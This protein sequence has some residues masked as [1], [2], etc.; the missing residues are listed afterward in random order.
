[1]LL[2]QT[3]NPN[4]LD[5]TDSHFCSLVFLQINTMTSTTMVYPWKDARNDGKKYASLTEAGRV[6]LKKYQAR[7]VTNDDGNGVRWK[8]DRIFCRPCFLKH[9]NK[10]TSQPQSEDMRCGCFLMCYR[11]TEKRGFVRCQ[12]FEP[13]PRRTQPFMIKPRRVIS[14]MDVVESKPAELEEERETETESLIASE[15]NVASCEGADESVEAPA[16]PKGHGFL[17]RMMVIGV[18]CVIGVLSCF[19]AGSGS[20]GAVASSTSQ[21]RVIVGSKALITLG[22]NSY[23]PVSSDACSLTLSNTFAVV[24]VETKVD[25]G[26]PENFAVL[27]ELLRVLLSGS[28]SSKSKAVALSGSR[29]L[30]PVSTLTCF[31][32]QCPSL[33]ETHAR[34]KALVA[35]DDGDANTMIPVLALLDSTPDYFSLE[36]LT[37]GGRASVS[38]RLG[39][40]ALFH[41]EFVDRSWSWPPRYVARVLGLYLCAIAVLVRI[42]AARDGQLDEDFDDFNL[43]M[44]DEEPDV[45]E[46][47]SEEPDVDFNFGVLDEEPDVEESESEE[48]EEEV[49]TEDEAPPA[50]PLRRSA[51]VAAMR[52][53]AALQDQETEDDTPQVTP[54]RRSSRV[55]ARPPINYPRETP[56]RKTRK[57]TKRRAA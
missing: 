4:F 41:V 15:Y 34:S 36:L 13:E 56:V 33:D 6:A 39:S 21:A 43:G 10:N 26:V 9:K 55:A 17:W 23:A 42:N 22:T 20:T 30:V 28:M 19:A 3:T 32:T 48:L 31:A 44:L 45:E 2:L 18:L 27:N 57:R 5:S 25:V 11:P 47:E 14:R 24:P 1:M 8:K 53:A 50:P 52:Q 37:R 46:S 38:F 49:E 35:V 29:A 7:K 12:I 51:R 16:V 54:L 40:T